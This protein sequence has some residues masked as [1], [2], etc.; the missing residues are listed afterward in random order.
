M[1]PTEYVWIPHRPI[2]RLRDTVLAT[3][4]ACSVFNCSL[5]TNK[6]PS[7]NEAAY[8]GIDIMNE[9]MGLLNYFGTNKI[10]SRH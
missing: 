6:G 2:I 5:K 8:A 3:T 9:L 4:E 10:V 7:L 1:N